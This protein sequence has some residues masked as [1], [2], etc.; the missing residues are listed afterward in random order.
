MT[1]DWTTHLS[2]PEKGYADFTVD[3]PKV[4]SAEISALGFAV[5]EYLEGSVAL[6]SKAKLSPGGLITMTVES[7][8]NNAKLEV[9]QIHWHKARGEGG[10]IDFSL[11][12][13][14]N[15]LHAKDINIELGH[16]K[17]D[18]DVKIDVKWPLISLSLEQ[19]SLSY[20]QLKGLKLERDESKNLI[21][22]LQGGEASLEPFL[23]ADEQGADPLHKQV[24]VQ[25]KAVVQK[26]R[27]AGFTF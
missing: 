7:D 9:P 21:F 22:T 25:S 6:K 3:A 27:S 4:S 15:H 2:G 20:A 19:L 1:V 5:N 18:G 17:T 11:S 10:S 23:S 16:L 12:V 26:L 13:E 24:A 8:F 14:K